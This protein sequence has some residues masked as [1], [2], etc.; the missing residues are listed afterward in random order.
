MEAMLVPCMFTIHAI[1]IESHLWGQDH[2]RDTRAA[3]ACHLAGVDKVYPH[4]YFDSE[5]SAI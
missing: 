4:N 3:N 5:A 1:Y 2:C